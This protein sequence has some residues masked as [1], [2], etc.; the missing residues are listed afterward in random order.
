MPHY[1]EHQRQH[2]HEINISKHPKYSINNQIECIRP[3]VI[4]RHP[5]AEIGHR[6]YFSSQ[7]LV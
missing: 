3:G 7:S 1:D 6:G 5:N 2:D 4:E